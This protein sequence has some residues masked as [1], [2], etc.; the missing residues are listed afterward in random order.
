MVK[1]RLKIILLIIAIIIIG[2]VILDLSS[3][4]EGIH[5]S[6]A[7]F[8]LS[9]RILQPYEN[10][11][12]DQC[13]PATFDFCEENRCGWVA[14]PANTWSNIAFVIAGIYLIIRYW[15]DK[16]APIK[17]L[18]IILI[19]LGISSGLYHASCIFTFQAADL[20]SMFL[21]SVLFLTLNLRRLNII[22]KHQIYLFFW[23]LTISSIVILA[24]FH[25]FGRLAFTIQVV[26]VIIT[27]FMIFHAKAKNIQ[28][29]SYYKEMLLGLGSFLIGYIV[30]I[31]D[32][33]QLITSPENH[34]FQGHALWHVFC[35]LSLVFFYR[36]YNRFN[37]PPAKHTFISQKDV[38]SERIH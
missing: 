5:G 10:C 19:F 28:F 30:W 14:Q 9:L 23:G 18:P 7:R 26:S 34:Y 16:W 24:V 27:E 12:W 2:G 11:P 31:L 33:K 3:N 35:A 32:L 25:K 20:S 17:H 38:L 37:I 36:F 21:C 6:I 13:V 15:K 29:F 8:V 4:K 1:R 22:N